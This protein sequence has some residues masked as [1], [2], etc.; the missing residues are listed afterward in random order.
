[1]NTQRRL[2]FFAVTVAVLAL[3]LSDV[4]VSQ[5]ALDQGDD[6]AKRSP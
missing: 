1:M 2:S 4:L 3:P 5:T 6:K